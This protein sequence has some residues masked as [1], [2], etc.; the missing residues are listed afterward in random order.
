MLKKSRTTLLDRDE[1][2]LKKLKQDFSREQDNKTLSIIS[3]GSESLIKKR[4]LETL[5][6]MTGA[7]TYACKI[8]YL[9]PPS[10]FFTKLMNH[11]NLFRW[12][13]FLFVMG[14]MV[15]TVMMSLDLHLVTTHFLQRTTMD[16]IEIVN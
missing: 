14:S 3:T 5:H 13:I 4:H 6:D 12:S 7:L 8:S 1:E 9:S 2:L 16:S 10:G 11:N 15:V